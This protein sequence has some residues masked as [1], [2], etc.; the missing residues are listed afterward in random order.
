MMKKL[1]KYVIGK[2]IATNY[3][4]SPYLI[5]A[6]LQQATITTSLICITITTVLQKR[7]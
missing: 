3:E 6:H 7:L 2:G 5:E 1:K 4:P